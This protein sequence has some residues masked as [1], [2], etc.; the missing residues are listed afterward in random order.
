METRIFEYKTRFPVRIRHAIYLYNDVLYTRVYMAVFEIRETFADLRR[1][2]RPIIVN[3][4]WTLRVCSIVVVY[5]FG[6]GS[7]RRGIHYYSLLLCNY[8]YII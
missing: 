3:R 8:T 7:P 1:L 5:P 6:I 2:S 4:Q